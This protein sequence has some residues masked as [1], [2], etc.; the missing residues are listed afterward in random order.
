MRLLRQLARGGKKADE[1]KLIGPA[2]DASAE[3]TKQIPS[4]WIRKT[5]KNGQGTKFLD[6]KNPKGNNVRVQ[7]GNPNSPNP[8]QQK[9]YVKQTQNGKSVD[10]NGKPVNPD[11][12]ES[13]I[14]KEDFKFKKE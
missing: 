10:A 12:K 3:V 13:H 11:S 7:G 8:G 1:V 9:P 2:G 6:P 5:S 14:P 4:D